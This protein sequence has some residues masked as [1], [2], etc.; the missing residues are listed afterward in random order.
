MRNDYPNHEN[1]DWYYDEEIISEKDLKDARTVEWIFCVAIVGLV[2][3]A[4][5]A[6]VLSKKGDEQPKPEEARL[7]ALARV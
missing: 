2:A 7:I 5:L 6:Y 1:D 4:V 3:L